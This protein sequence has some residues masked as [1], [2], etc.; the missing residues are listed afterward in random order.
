[1][2]AEWKSLFKI[3]FDNEQDL[4]WV[5]DTRDFY[6]NSISNHYMNTPELPDLQKLSKHP[7]RFFSTPDEVKNILADLY[8]R[9]GGEGEWRFISFKNQEKKITSNWQL[10]YL[11]IFKTD[12]GLLICDKDE[13]PI[14]KDLFDEEI[15]E[16]LLAHQ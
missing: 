11:V 1:M 6:V 4:Y 14:R 2:S 9:S 3:D 5:V 16:E 7:N 15:D 12:H 13:V 10:K 8:Y